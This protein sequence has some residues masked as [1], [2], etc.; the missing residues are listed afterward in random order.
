L[1]SEKA[2]NQPDLIPLPDDHPAKA[3]L[4][5]PPVV[6]GH[7]LSA[8]LVR[9]GRK[10]S[11][12][13]QLERPNPSGR[14]TCTLLYTA[15][16]SW[17]AGHHQAAL[18]VAIHWFRDIGGF[19]Q[20]A[21]RHLCHI[22]QRLIEGVSEREM[23]AAVNAYAASPWH[24]EQHAAKKTA[25]TTI[26]RFFVAGEKNDRGLLDKW[27]ENCPTLRGERDQANRSQADAE[28]NR[29]LAQ[30]HAAQRARE[31]E[32]LA[33]RRAQQHRAEQS[34]DSQS[35]RGDREE[36]DPV[37]PVLPSPISAAIEQLP[38]SDR[39]VV[40]TLAD[41]KPKADVK[42][43]AVRQAEAVLARL[44]PLLPQESRNSID[45]RWSLMYFHRVNDLLGPQDV[46]ESLLCKLRMRGL[47]TVYREER[48]RKSPGESVG[49]LTGRQVA[50]PMTDARYNAESDRRRRFAR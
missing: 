7:G 20:I 19:R 17:S 38:K 14:R 37:A 27:I 50:N 29:R 42:R 28:H 21:K 44:W 24:R 11:G 40:P 8:T 22:V 35:R 30:Q 48:G 31:R 2:L 33:A 18:A 26:Q 5:P 23:H 10:I 36:A 47:I 45:A 12:T 25:W 3:A 1:A 49:P 13:V 16:A 34:R 15:P 43:R 9:D 4:A 46:P 6:V 41:R 32:R 39:W